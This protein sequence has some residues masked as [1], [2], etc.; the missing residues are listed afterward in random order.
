M[1]YVPTCA[2]FFTLFMTS[3]STNQQSLRDEIA[4]LEGRLRDAK[5]QLDQCDDVPPA[6]LADDAGLLSRASDESIAY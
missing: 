5:A 3:P 4:D 1:S 6:K 2:S